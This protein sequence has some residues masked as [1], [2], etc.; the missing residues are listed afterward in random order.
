MLR[1]QHAAFRR[2]LSGFNR[3]GFRKVFHLRG[4]DEVEAATVERE[5]SWNDRRTVH[6]PFDIVGDVHGCHD[7]LVTL[8]TALGWQLSGDY[9]THPDGR[10]AVF[11]GD[12]VDRGPASP[13]VLRLVMAMVRS[14]AALC[15]PGNH[16]AKLLRALKGA[17]VTP[18]HGLDRTLAQLALEP[19]SFRD[20]V[21]RFLDGL[22]SHLVLD[23]GKLV[24][25]HAGL[26][27]EMHNRQSGVVR[28]FALYGD[29]TGETDEYGLPVRY[30]WAEEYRG[31]ARW[32][33]AT[34]R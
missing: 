31:R 23:D 17:N 22:V 15:V 9:A 18:S 11:V 32:S 2:S 34:P 30:P 5:P 20:E 3:E 6:G 7:E 26:R 8:L 13:A 12:L 1:N 19:E 4:V 28:S 14:G 33:T 27:E 25:A 21:R 10:I 29:T 24:V 16:D